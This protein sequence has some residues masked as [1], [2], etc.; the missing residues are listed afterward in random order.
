MQFRGTVDELKPA[1]ELAVQRLGVIPRYVEAATLCGPFGSERA[2]DHVAGGLHCTGSKLD[3]CVSLFRR[4]Q[5][6][7]YGPVVPHVE[8]VGR[9][10]RLRDISANPMNPF[11]RLSEAGFRHIQGGLRDIQDCQVVVTACQKIID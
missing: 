3:V 6:V 1:A 8:G 11:S 4:I 5:E 7:K 10:V 2:Y 9:Q